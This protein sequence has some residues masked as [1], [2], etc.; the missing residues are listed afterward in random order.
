M[1][2]PFPCSV[3]LYW[4]SKG[5]PLTPRGP[6]FCEQLGAASLPIYC[7][8][9]CDWIKVKTRAWRGPTGTAP[10][11][12]TRVEGRRQFRPTKA[13]VRTGAP[14][15][16]PRAA[17]AGIRGNAST[18]GAFPT[19][20]RVSGPYKKLSRHPPSRTPGNAGPRTAARGHHLRPRRDQEPA[21]RAA[22]CGGSGGSG[23]TSR[24]TKSS[25]TRSGCPCVL[26]RGACQPWLHQPS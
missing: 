6:S 5:P 3:R 1:W 14:R 22:C 2:A 21:G 26:R 15:V 10:R 8:G 25:R 17:L 11:C 20:P 23:K 9:K 13:Q 12:S 4:K 18:L 19:P 16:M 7:S 24:M